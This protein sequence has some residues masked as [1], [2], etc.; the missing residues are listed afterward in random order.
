MI[1]SGSW[2]SSERRAVE[3][4][5]AARSLTCTWLTIGR[6]YSVGSSTV[7]MLVSIELIVARQA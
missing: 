1:T 2:R 3:K 7:Q 5:S 4:V 6:L